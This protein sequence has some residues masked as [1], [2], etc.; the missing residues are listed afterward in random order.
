[1]QINKEENRKNVISALNYLIIIKI[2]NLLILLTYLHK[3]KFLF[4]FFISIQNYYIKVAER[5]RE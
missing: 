1:M 5:I 3:A 2:S 4:Y